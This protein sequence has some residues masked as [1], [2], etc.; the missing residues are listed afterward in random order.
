M[1]SVARL[2]IANLDNYITAE[3][4]ADVFW[5]QRICQA[6]C[7]TMVPNEGNKQT[8]YVTVGYWFS[9]VSAVN[10]RKRING[11]EARIVY[12]DDFWWPVQITST[13]PRDGFATFMPIDFF[14]KMEEIE[15]LAE[16]HYYRNECYFDNCDD[17][18]ENN[19]DKWIMPYREELF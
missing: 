6:S 8:A 1:S 17:E 13:K 16:H 18:I 4:V 14:K 15:R 3:F 19:E 9:N 5:R 11:G 2:M 7:I 10:F 12:E